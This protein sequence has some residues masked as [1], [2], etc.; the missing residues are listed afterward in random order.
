MSEHVWTTLEAMQG[1]IAREIRVMLGEEQLDQKLFTQEQRDRRIEA[2]KKCAREALSDED[3]H[4]SWM[5]MHEEMGWVYGPEFNPAR[6]THP[7]ML[8][9][10]QLWPETRSKAKIFAIVAQA[11][12]VL[13]FDQPQGESCDTE[14]SDTRSE[15]ER[16]VGIECGKTSSEELRAKAFLWTTLGN[17]II[18]ATKVIDTAILKA[19]E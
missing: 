11:G 1:Q 9:W 16:A 5:K 18:S 8:P 13:A 14:A 12:K 19:M 15:D 2:L 7:N 4:I 10:E 6:K 17:L 3:C